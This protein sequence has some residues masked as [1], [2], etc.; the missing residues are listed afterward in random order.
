MTQCRHRRQLMR[1]ASR[2]I[3]VVVIVAIALSSSVFAEDVELTTASIED[4]NRAFDTGALTSER[5]VELSLAR[6]AAYDDSGPMLNAVIFVN[7]NALAEARALDVERLAKG[8][9]SP[10]HGIPVVLKDNIDTADMPTTAGSFMLKGSFPPDDAFLVRKL[11]DAGAIILAKLNMSEFASGDAMSSLAG[12]IYNPH[13]P[14]RTPSGSSGGTGAAIAAAYAPI[15]LGTDTGGSVRGPSASNGIVG[16]KPTLGLLSRDGII[17][18]ALS[19]DTAG[20]MGRSVHDVAVAL[21]VMTGV[22]TADPATAKSRGHFKTEYTQYLDANALSGARIGIARD[23]MDSDEE[24]DW[25][26]EAALQ[27]M[28]DAG[29]EVVDVELPEW[30]LDS[31]GKF[32]RAIRYR[33]FRSQ[34]ADYLA[35]IGP[36]YPKTLTE[37][38]RQSKTVTAHRADGVISNPG[39]WQLMMKEEESGEL[40]DYEYIAVRDHALPLIRGIVGGLIAAENLDAIVYPTSHVRPERVDPDPDPDGAPGSGGSPVILANLTGFPDLIVP[41]GFTGRGL[42]VAISFMGPAFSE[43]RLLSLGFAFE[44][45]TKARRLPTTTPPLPGE[46]IIY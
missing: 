8:R 37:M 32:Y 12:P 31:R 17:P 36:D 46:M 25:I 30:L 19:F 11:R 41:A 42:P 45:L 29:A 38:V 34:I 3:H 27:A 28:R 20:P 24:V 14:A 10:M 44:S 7:P 26:V 39:R 4:I 1:L 2:Q 33:E 6:I 23:F 13:D 21:G 5:L 22:D 18:L 9:R 40:T 43:P 15:G 16:L 35:T